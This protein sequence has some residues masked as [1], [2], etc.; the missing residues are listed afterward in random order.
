M[1]VRLSEVSARGVRAA[2]ILAAAI[3]SLGMLPSR[4][5]ALADD[6]VINYDEAKVPPYEL[7]D[8]LVMQSGKRVVTAKAWQNARRPE[9]LNLFETQVYGRPLPV[10]RK[11]RFNVREEQG[12]LGGRAIR[13]RVKVEIWSGGQFVPAFTFV[14]YQ[15]RSQGRRAPAF[16]GMHLFDKEADEPQP[17]KPLEQDV[18][19][20]LPGKNLMRTI[21]ARGYAVASLDAK[22]FCPD[23]K[24]N[25]CDGVLTALFP[26]RS[27]DPAAEEAGAIGTWAWG[28]SRALDYFECDPTIDARRV[29]VIGHSRMGKTALW[30]GAQ[31]QRFAIVISNNSGCGG[32]ALSR[33]IFGETVARINRVFPHWFCGNFKKY[34]DREAE[35]PVDQHEL[36]ALVAPRPVYVASALEDRWADPRGELLAAQGAQGVYR[37]FGL[38]GLELTGDPPLNQPLG[39]NIGYH[40]RVG[41]H[42]LTDYD[43]LA[44]LDF[45]D[46]HFHRGSRPLPASDVARSRA[47]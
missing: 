9:L 11:V 15:P 14:L 36:I 3:L 35:L 8:P 42:A 24:A 34:N 29:A 40:L 2:A 10:P 37:L 19:R 45:A 1:R 16:V 20:E 4:A 25:F 13:K 27:G 12:V 46:R 5:V 28:L 32:A 6:G 33:R 17:G 41:K 43:W 22:D 21:L 18:G 7:P 30:A 39:A 31:D 38:R 44:Y 26:D 23:D 47:R